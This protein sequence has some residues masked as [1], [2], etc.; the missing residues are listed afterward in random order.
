MAN[1]K[2]GWI[3]IYRDIWDN[4]L[5]NSNEPF[6]VRSAWIDLILMANHEDAEIV[7]GKTVHKIKR[8]QLHTSAKSLSTRWTWSLNKIRAYIRLL[9]DLGMITTESTT[10]GTTLTIVNYSKFQD[11]PHTEGTTKGTSKGTTNGTTNGTSKGTTNGTQTRSIKKAEAKER[12]KKEKGTLG[13]S[14]DGT[15]YDH[16]E[17]VDGVTWYCWKDAEGSWHMENESKEEYPRW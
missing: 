9:K 10:H 8:G 7:I 6:D 15:P 5:W 4:K 3:K 2:N 1:K 11:L 13:I 12:K 16:T 14:S 17:E